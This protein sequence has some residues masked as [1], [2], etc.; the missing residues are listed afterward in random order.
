MK[1]H[2]TTLFCVSPIVIAF[3]VLLIGF[4]GN[5]VPH[6]SGGNETMPEI[7][8]AVFDKT[9]QVS[10]IDTTSA[11]IKIAEKNSKAI[12]AA[13]KSADKN[14]AL[15]LPDG[16]IAFCGPLDIKNKENI[17]IR[18]GEN[19]E[20]LNVSYDS[21]NR[22]GEKANV[23]KIRDSSNVYI[24][25]IAIDFLSH[26]TADG[27]ITEIQNGRTYFEIYPE[28]ISGNKRA[29]VGGE[30]VYSVLTADDTVFLDESW[31][32]GGS[33]VLKKESESIFSV[34][35]E[36]GKVGNRICCRISCG[37]VASPSIFV[38]R[39][40][41][42]YLDGITCYSCPSAFIYAPYGNANFE[43]SNLK[44]GVRD[45]SKALLA[46]NE[47]CIHAKHIK[48]K[49]SVTDSSFYGIG[50]DALNSHTKLC[51]VESVNESTITCVVGGDNSTPADGIFNK[52]D[53]VELIGRNYKSLGTAVVVKQEGKTLVLESV[54]ENV[55]KGCL[56]QNITYSPEV[57]FKNCKVGFGRARGV[58]L[59][60]KNA[61]VEGCTFENLRLSAVLVAPDFEYWYEGGFTENLTVKGNVFR[62]CTNYVKNN[63]FAVVHI[64]SS[65]DQVQNKPNVE[66]HKNVTVTENTFED[67]DGRHVRATST[68]N[69]VTDAE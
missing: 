65:H 67:C 39:T 56:I 7:T 30:K 3:S 33:T 13:I 26:T 69:F 60:A 16:V 21:V 48:G 2:R 61:T 23:F 34:S 19:T 45:G 17:A 57:T 50:D 22:S 47:D 35:M 25:N 68:V 36:I 66:G 10:G 1:K 15:L 58:L 63:G 4:F 29:I 49:L 64:N 8:Q 5:N 51:V 18:G 46:S 11:D 38:N 6:T 27:I 43:F 28:F 40:N 20:L 59:Q 54:P 31:P 14:T 24:E 62:N 41:G 53:T 9:V 52:G 32:E 37:N 42:L 44:I 55:N 12:E